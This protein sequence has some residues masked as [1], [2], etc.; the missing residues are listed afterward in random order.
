MIFY[1]IAAPEGHVQTTSNV[2]RTISVENFFQMQLLRLYHRNRY[3]K[4]KS[5]VTHSIMDHVRLFRY[6]GAEYR[7]LITTGKVIKTNLNLPHS[8]PNSDKILV[9]GANEQD[10]GAFVDTI[11]SLQDTDT[12]GQYQHLI[13]HSDSF[14]TLLPLAKVLGPLGLM[15]SPSKGTVG[16][17]VK[18]MVGNVRRTSRIDSSKGYIDIY[19]G[20]ETFS[21]AKIAENIKYVVNAVAAMRPAR[22]NSIFV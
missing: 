7:L 10:L 14:K 4:Q 13:C 17:D 5:N 12:L 21:D 16:T 2:R 6:Y 9:V 8:V 20:P 15:P 11:P 19:I 22:T 3:L 1:Q 18:E